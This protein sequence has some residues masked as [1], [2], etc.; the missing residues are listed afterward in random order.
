MV[1]ILQDRHS[2]VADHW[3]PRDNGGKINA[4]AWNPW[5]REGG[6]VIDFEHMSKTQKRLV[7]TAVLLE[8]WRQPGLAKLQRDAI[9][10][11]E[12]LREWI[13]KEGEHRNVCT[14]PVLGVTCKDCRCGK[15][16]VER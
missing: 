4:V 15:Y 11:I 5:H 13:A 16:P 8:S 10:E 7:K 14:Q 9:Y 3:R 2:D 1:G 6:D 12:A